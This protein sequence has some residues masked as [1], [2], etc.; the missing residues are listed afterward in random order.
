MYAA[1]FTILSLTI[2]HFLSPSF[3]TTSVQLGT[4]G[5]RCPIP[6]AF[7]VRLDGALSNLI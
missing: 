1:P 3:I 6:G 2:K 7:K 5:G 4:P